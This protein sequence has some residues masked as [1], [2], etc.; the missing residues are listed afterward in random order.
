ME[1]LVISFSSGPIDVSYPIL[2]QDSR[3]MQPLMGYNTRG[4]QIEHP[5]GDH[6]AVAYLV[7]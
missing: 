4:I 1:R 6:C 3:K 2:A 5:T 7:V